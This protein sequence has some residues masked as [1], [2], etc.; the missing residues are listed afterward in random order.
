MGFQKLEY[1]TVSSTK[2]KGFNTGIHKS[3]CLKRDQ[4]KT[5]LS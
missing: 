5:I 3:K 4:N 1:K 2:L